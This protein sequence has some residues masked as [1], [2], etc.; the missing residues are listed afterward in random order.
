MI[1]LAAG[2]G[3]A[4]LENTI[5]FLNLIQQGNF[6]TLIF[7]FFLRFAIST[8]AHISFGGIMGALLARGLF[9]VY[10]PKRQLFQAFALPWLVHGLFDLLLSINLSM[11][12][13][14]L[15]LPPLFIMIFWSSRRDYFV[16]NRQGK[17]ILVGQRAPETKEARL[18]QRFFKQFD[19]PWNINAP[20]LGEKRLRRALLQGLEDNTP[21]E[22]YTKK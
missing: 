4:T 6:D 22:Q 17:E 18:M 16:I 3:F 20:W 12:A 1:G 9:S 7:V 11:Y 5:Y 19:S 21:A 2:L 8:L 15:L 13:V 10:R 14:I